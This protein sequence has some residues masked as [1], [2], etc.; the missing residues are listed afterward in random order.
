MIGWRA[1]LAAGRLK[2]P[3]IPHG[4][5]VLHLNLRPDPNGQKWSQG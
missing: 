1:G 2:A 3:F 5:P 4:K